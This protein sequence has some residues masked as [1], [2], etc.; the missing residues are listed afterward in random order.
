MQAQGA[1]KAVEGRA[2]GFTV[3][4][5]GDL[6]RRIE[7]AGTPGHRVKSKRVAGALRQGLEHV[8]R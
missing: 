5:A 4:A 1:E 6:Q 2:Q 7:P 3:V 8:G